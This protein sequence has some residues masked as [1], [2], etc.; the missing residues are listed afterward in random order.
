[1]WSTVIGEIPDPYVGQLRACQLARHLAEG[2]DC[3]ETFT[4]GKPFNSPAT[5]IRNYSSCLGSPLPE[6]TYDL[7][8]QRFDE[9]RE[10]GAV[11][12]LHEGLDRHSGNE[13]DIAQTGDLLGGD[14]DSCGVIAQ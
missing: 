14:A 13:P 2:L 4:V 12:G 10:D 9:I 5:T 6:R 1:M 3:R 8:L 11:I 7:I